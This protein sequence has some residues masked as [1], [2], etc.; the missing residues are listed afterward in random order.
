MGLK[1]TEESDLRD[2]EYNLTSLKRR[3]EIEETTE[4]ENDT[5]SEQIYIFDT[6]LRDAEQTPGAALNL[7]EK[8]EIAQHLAK[9]NVDIIEAGFPRFIT[10]R[11]RCGR[12]Y[13]ERGRRGQKSAHFH[14]SLRRTSLRHGVQS[15]MPRNLVSI[16][17]LARRIFTSQELLAPIVK[18][19]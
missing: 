12:T 3:T 15:R 11:L 8:L 9:L 6:T 5:M 1:T 7:E 13:R 2:A 16:P 10:W 4:K 14:E 17:L 18:Q 19:Y